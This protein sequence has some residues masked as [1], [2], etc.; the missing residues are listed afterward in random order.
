MS[1]NLEREKIHHTL[2][3]FIKYQNKLPI[4]YI[5]L[6]LLFWLQERSPRHKHKTNLSDNS[7]KT[8]NICT[9]IYTKF[10]HE[11]IPLRYTSEISSFKSLWMNLLM[12]LTSIAI[13]PRSTWSLDRTS[14]STWS[15]VFN[16]WR[17]LGVFFLLRK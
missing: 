17:K 12:R 16:F 11:S 4:R 6:L 7:I 13:G 9:I 15:L 2:N 8:Y 10:G 14:L 1:I 3:K 5:K